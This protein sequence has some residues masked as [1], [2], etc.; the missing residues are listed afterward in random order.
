MSGCQWSR[1]SKGVAIVAAA[2]GGRW[3]VVGYEAAASSTTTPPFPF[4]GIHS[5]VAA[6]RLA[7]SQRISLEST[8][9][10]VANHL[11]AAVAVVDVGADLDHTRQARIICRGQLLSSS[12]PQAADDGHLDWRAHC[13]IH[14][15]PNNC[16]RVH[17][18]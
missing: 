16:C 11:G 1:V 10:C 7:H 8:V 18:V 3:S 13:R 14:A 9:S 12:A 5:P 6:R 15:V 2:V 17:R 4:Q